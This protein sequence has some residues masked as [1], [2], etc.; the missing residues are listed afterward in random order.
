MYKFTDNLFIWNL[1]NIASI[2]VYI[3]VVMTL[4]SLIQS[5]NYA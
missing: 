3:Q 4:D 1:A 2:H 5:N